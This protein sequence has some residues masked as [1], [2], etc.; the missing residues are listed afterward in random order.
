VKNLFKYGEKD[1]AKDKQAYKLF[2]LIQLMAAL[3]HH[4]LYLAAIAT[5]GNEIRLGG[6]E[7]PPR[8]FSVFLGTALSNL[9]DGKEAPKVQNL[10]DLSTSISFDANQ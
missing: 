8:I 3:R 1:S 7:A 2:I 10:R 6:H 5:P 4:K 9:L